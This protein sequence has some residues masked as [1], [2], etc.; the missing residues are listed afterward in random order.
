MAI[1]GDKHVGI[2][3][4][5]GG[6][7]EVVVGIGD[8]NPRRRAWADQLNRIRVVG[9]HLMCRTAK[10]CEPPL[11]AGTHQHVAQ[12]R[13]QHRT[14]EEPNVLVASHGQEEL[15]WCTPPQQR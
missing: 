7:D 3:C 8:D 11:E 13:Q 15:V 2:R 6:N 5:S 14:A 4:N 12:F 10:N 1:A 9:E